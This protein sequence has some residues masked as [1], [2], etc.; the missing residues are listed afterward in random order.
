MYLGKATNQKVSKRTVH[1][2]NQT[3]RTPLCKTGG[4]RN[5]TIYADQTTC[6]RCLAKM[7][8]C[9]HSQFVEPGLNPGE[10]RI[11]AAC[12]VTLVPCTGEAHSNPYIDNCGVCMPQWGWIAKRKETT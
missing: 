1:K 5:A 9:E 12:G 6:K 11:C 4:A 3:T 8:K 2:M 7:D 10:T